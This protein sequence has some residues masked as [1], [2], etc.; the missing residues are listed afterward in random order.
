MV[1]EGIGIK[2][3]Q[4]EEER[5]GMID[6]F[7]MRMKDIEFDF[8]EIIKDVIIKEILGKGEVNEMI[9]IGILNIKVFERVKRGE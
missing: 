7:V 5:G 6:G 3:G 8:K 4:I 1:G 9:D 2:I